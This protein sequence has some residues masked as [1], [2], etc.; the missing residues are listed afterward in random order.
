MVT[1]F[2]EELSLVS[3]FLRERLALADQ[4]EDQAR[5]ATMVEAARDE[6]QTITLK[7][8]LTQLQDAQDRVKRLEG[9]LRM[10]VGAYHTRHLGPFEIC[11]ERCCR[12]AR[13]ILR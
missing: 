4:A 5:R 6:V 3:Q 13:E 9:A 11:Q 10:V 2:E 8:L 12:L 1:E 7:E